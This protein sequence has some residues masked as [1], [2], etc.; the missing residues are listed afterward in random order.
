MSKKKQKKNEQQKD[1]NI[2]TLYVDGM[3]CASCEIL[4]EKKLLKEKGIKGADAS[5]NNNKVEIQYSGKKPNAKKLSDSLKDL[6]YEL[7]EDEIGKDSTPLFQIKDG[8]LNVNPKKFKEKLK[9]FGI[10]FALLISFYLFE[11]LQLGQ[12]VSVDANSSLPAYF[13]LGIAAGLSSCAALVGGLLLSMV[14]QWNELYLGESKKNKAQPHILFHV[15]RLTAFFLGGGILGLI[16]KA[17]GGSVDDASFFSNSIFYS[18]VTI[19]ISVI[20]FI[21]AMQML[22]VKWAQKLRLTAPKSLTRLTADETRFKGKYMP[23]FIGASTFILPCGF[24]LLAQSFA[25]LSGSF[26]KGGLLMLLFSLGTLLPLSAISLSGLEFNKKPHLTAKFNQVAGLLIV[27]FVIYNINGQLNVLGA[28]SLSDIS[29]K[30]DNSDQ[31]VAQVVEGEVQKVTI[32]ARGFEYV[33]AGPM[34]INSG[35]P[36]Q[37]IVD[38]QGVQGCGSYI[39]AAGLISGF[40]PLKGGENVIDVGKP[41]PGTYKITCSMGMVQPITLTV[42]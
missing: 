19:I 21:I 7:S 26:I 32:I 39:A 15:G 29:F 23:F 28:P 5:L 30:S 2:C 16:F 37:L 42:I 3:H 33:P 6:G 4:I 41:E 17:L 36:T 12:I 34:T 1:T 38:N 11:K 22:D 25:F 31:E 35:V 27:F 8:E 20:M 10:L 40:V 18:V 14:K 13:L 9:V 24:T